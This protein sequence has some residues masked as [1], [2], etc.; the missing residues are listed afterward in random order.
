ME[1]VPQVEHHESL[2]KAICSNQFL[3]CSRDKAVFEGM[4]DSLGVAVFLSL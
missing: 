2:L 1:V 3:A 4:N